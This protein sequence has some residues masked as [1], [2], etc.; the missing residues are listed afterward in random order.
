MA[1]MVF[2]LR[3]RDAATRMVLRFAG[4]ES[5]SDVKGWLSDREECFTLG[6]VPTGEILPGWISRI[7]WTEESS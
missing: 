5:S 1:G 7:S 4:A 3:F 2:E 6:A